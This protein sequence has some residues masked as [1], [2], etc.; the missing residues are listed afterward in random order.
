MV[1]P[2]SLLVAALGQG[3]Q[4]RHAG[5]DPLEQLPLMGLDPLGLRWLRT[6]GVNANG[7]AAEVM[8]FCRI[9]KM[10]ALAFVGNEILSASSAAAFRVGIRDL[11]GHLTRK[12]KW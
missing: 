7:A 10:Y 11:G 2:E 6:N 5:V 4:Q 3:L 9:E 8:F 1:P 12:E